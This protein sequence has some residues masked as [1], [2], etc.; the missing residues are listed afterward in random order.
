M[1]V[2]PALL[3]TMLV[4]AVRRHAAVKTQRSGIIFLLCN[5]HNYNAG[6]ARNNY[7]SSCYFILKQFMFIR[8]I[9]KN[10]FLF[11]DDP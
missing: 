10:P 9:L 6:H 5:P 11:S 2:K 3:S 1:S 4:I 7:V 8:M